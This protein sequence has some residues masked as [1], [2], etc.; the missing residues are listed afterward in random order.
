MKICSSLGI[1]IPKNSIIK[2]F[3]IYKKSKLFFGKVKE[4]TTYFIFK[5]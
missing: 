2:N 5:K 4:L 3:D 1:K